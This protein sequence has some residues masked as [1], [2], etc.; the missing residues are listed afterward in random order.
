VTGLSLKDDFCGMA[1]NSSSKRS[2][3]NA[4]DSD[5]DSKDEVCDELSSLHKENMEL[6]DFPVIAITCLKKLRSLGRSLKLCLRMLELKW[7]S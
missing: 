5:S 2:Q 7:L 3:K 4:S 6:V 1:R